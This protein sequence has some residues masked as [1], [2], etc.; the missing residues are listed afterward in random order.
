LGGFFGGVGHAGFPGGKL[1]HQVTVHN[2]HSRVNTL[3][4]CVTWS[5]VS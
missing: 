1:Y 3:N 5:P 2:L 4:I